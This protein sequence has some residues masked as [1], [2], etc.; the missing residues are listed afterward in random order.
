MARLLCRVSRRGADDGRHC[1]ARSSA[2]E[3]FL[4]FDPLVELQ[5]ERLIASRVRALGLAE[6]IFAQR[7]S[8][9]EALGILLILAGAALAQQGMRVGGRAAE[10]GSQQRAVN[11]RSRKLAIAPLTRKTFLNTAR[12]SLLKSAMVLKSA[13]SRRSPCALEYNVAWA[14]LLLCRHATSASVREFSMFTGPFILLCPA[15][16][17]RALMLAGAVS[18]IFFSGDLVQFAVAG[19]F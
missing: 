7:T 10:C 15:A 16:Y 12:L 4:D 17:R 14:F 6:V 3:G 11:G 18:I 9:R 5:T 1:L 13:F 2:L 19:T 8:G